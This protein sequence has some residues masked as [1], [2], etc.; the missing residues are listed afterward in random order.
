MGCRLK[1]LN[2]LASGRNSK[3]YKEMSYTEEFREDGQDG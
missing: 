3:H 2:F 1:S